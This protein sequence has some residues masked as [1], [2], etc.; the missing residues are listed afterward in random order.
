MA[1]MSVADRK[2]V[3]AGFHGGQAACPCT[4]FRIGQLLLLRIQLLARRHN[5]ISF[6][7]DA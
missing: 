5:G 1:D 3:L 4:E 2:T 7:K 6:A